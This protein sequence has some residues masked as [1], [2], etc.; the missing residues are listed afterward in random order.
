MPTLPAPMLEAP[1]ALLREIRWETYEALLA[2]LESSRCRLVY[3][4]GDLEIMSPSHR[5][6]QWVHRARRLIEAMTLER[7]IP[8]HGGRSTTIRRRD[9]EVGVEPDECYWVQH[10]PAMRG[11]LEFDADLDPPPDLVLEGEASHTVLPR[12]PI[13]ARLGVGEV[14]RFDGQRLQVLGLD[15]A[16]ATYAAR[17]SS[18]CFPWLPLGPFAAHLVPPAGVDETSWLRG[19]LTWLGGAVPGP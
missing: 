10:E 1:H 14:W 19:F 9:L 8:I 11:R 2:D 16:A 17:S 18:A 12:L 15:G 5:H 7:G 13:Y 6:E 3:D 4:R